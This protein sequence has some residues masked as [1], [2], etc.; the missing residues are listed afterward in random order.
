M[1]KGRLLN[2]SEGADFLASFHDNESVM[3]EKQKEAQSFDGNKKGPQFK[4]SN[5]REQGTLE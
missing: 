3:G 4:E 5:Q 2:T 1:I